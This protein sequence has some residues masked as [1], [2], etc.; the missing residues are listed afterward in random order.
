[1]KKTLLLFIYLLCVSK[2]FSQQFLIS[3][4]ITDAQGKPVP[5]TSIYLKNTTQGTSANDRGLYQFK[6]NPGTYDVVYR[7]VGF[8]EKVEH[9]TIQNN[10]QHDVVL[11]KEIYQLKEVSI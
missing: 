5:F 2:A 4:K 6:L 11:D 3:G 7:F 9:L 10:L 1:M 8:K